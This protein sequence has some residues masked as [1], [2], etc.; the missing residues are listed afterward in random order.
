M[1]NCPFLLILITTLQSVSIKVK[2]PIWISIVPI[3]SR[4]WGVKGRKKKERIE[5]SP[6]PWSPPPWS[7]SVVGGFYEH[8]EYD[9]EC[10]SEWAEEHRRLLHTK[11]KLLLCH[12]FRFS[13]SRHTPA[14]S[15]PRGKGGPIGHSSGA[16]ITIPNL[17]PHFL[18]KMYLLLWRVD[19]FIP[20]GI[21]QFLNKN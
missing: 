17:S 4:V 3:G 12:S 9:Q 16:K 13:L 18:L 11:A 15:T 19:Y 10:C 14:R 5:D 2:F 21:F 6:P 1:E 20:Y 7:R 8:E